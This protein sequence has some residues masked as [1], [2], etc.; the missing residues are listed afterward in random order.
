MKVEISQS[1][2]R[3]RRIDNQITANEKA[4]HDA[5]AVKLGQ[6]IQQQLANVRSDFVPPRYSPEHLNLM[7][8]VNELTEEVGNYSGRP[9]QAQEEWIAMF[10]VQVQQ[11]LNRLER[12]I[13]GDLKQLNER[14]A[15]GHVPNV[16]PQSELQQ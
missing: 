2:E 15:A 1:L 12:V 13:S 7:I 3:I 11:V 9:T 5:D 14:L 6:K 8:R 16:S 10:E 4:W